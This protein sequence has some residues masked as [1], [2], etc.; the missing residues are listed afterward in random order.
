MEVRF[1]K[2]NIE[3]KIQLGN[4]ALPTVLNSYR[5]FVEV[6]CLMLSHT[7]LFAGFKR[8]TEIFQKYL[9]A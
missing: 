1:Q 5:D 3:A 9:S 8:A 2:L 7:T 4:R 6:S